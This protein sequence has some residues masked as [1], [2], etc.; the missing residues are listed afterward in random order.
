MDSRVFEAVKKKRRIM[1]RD[2][3]RNVEDALLCILMGR[4]LKEDP[5]NC[6]RRERAAT[7]ERKKA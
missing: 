3:V 1:R 6:N 7:A 4:K 5:E 2:K